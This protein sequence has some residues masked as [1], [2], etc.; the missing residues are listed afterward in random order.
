LNRRGGVYDHAVSNRLDDQNTS[1]IE[2]VTPAIPAMAV[3]ASGAAN[4]GGREKISLALTSSL[5]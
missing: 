5:N 2:R 1:G 4:S 3:G